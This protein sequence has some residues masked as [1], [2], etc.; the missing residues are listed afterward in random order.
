MTGIIEIGLKSDG[1]VGCGT[2]GT[3]VMWAVFHCVGT[4]ASVIDLG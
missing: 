2:L 1:S 4:L 3:G